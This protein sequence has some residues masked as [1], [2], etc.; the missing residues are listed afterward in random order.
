MTERDAVSHLRLIVTRPEGS[1][2][3][4]KANRRKPKAKQLA[5]PYP[6]AS[7]VFLVYVESID[8][9]EFAKIVGDCTPRWVIDVRAVPRLDTIAASRISAFNLF[10]HAKATYIDLFGRLG[11]KTYRAAESN[12]AFWSSTVVDLLKNSDRK[13]PYLFLFDNEQMMKTAD[14]VLRGIMLSLVD[15]TVHFTHIRHSH[16]SHFVRGGD[17]LP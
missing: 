7:T 1:E 6:E 15:K 8:R 2:D 5:F 16:R 14:D 17:S 10:E 12:P 11:I 9:E 3:R 13:G 4:A